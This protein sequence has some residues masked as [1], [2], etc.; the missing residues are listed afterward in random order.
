MRFY[1]YGNDSNST[2]NCELISMGEHLPT[3]SSF[4]GT[5]LD[6]IY[7]VGFLTNELKL[8]SNDLWGVGLQ[9]R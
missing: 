5:L 4:S 8:V 2:P 6:S 3:V 9:S 1:D 7:L